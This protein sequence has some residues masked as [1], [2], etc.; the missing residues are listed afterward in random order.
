LANEFK[1]HLAKAA[2]ERERAE[3]GARRAEAEEREKRATYRSWVA[4]GGSPAEFEVAWR[5]LRAETLKRRTLQAEETAR[6]EQRRRTLS[7][8]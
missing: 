2:R 8:F 6:A 5:E 7:G 3:E 1:T 4:S